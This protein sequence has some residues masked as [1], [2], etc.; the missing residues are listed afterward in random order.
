MRED[1]VHEKGVKRYPVAVGEE[2]EVDISECSP[3]GEGIAKVEGLVIHVPNAK[4]GKHVKIKISRIGGTTAEANKVIQRTKMLETT[5]NAKPFFLLISNE[6]V[7][8]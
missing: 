6:N 1:V 7:V 3:K 4:L 2:L 8:S 5:L